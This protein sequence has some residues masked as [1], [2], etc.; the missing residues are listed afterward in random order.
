MFRPASERAHKI[1]KTGGPCASAKIRE[2]CVSPPVP[3]VQAVG[4]WHKRHRREAFGS[5]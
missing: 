5:E 1:G 4:A 2:E 3:G